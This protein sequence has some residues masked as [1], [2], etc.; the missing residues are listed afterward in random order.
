MSERTPICR[1]IGQLPV[2]CFLLTC[3]TASLLL[4]TGKKGVHPFISHERS[5]GSV[6]EDWQS[7]FSWLYLANIGP[8]HRTDGAHHEGAQA[9]SCAADPGGGRRWQSM[10]DVASRHRLNDVNESCQ[11]PADE[12]VVD[13]PLY[14][15][16]ASPKGSQREPR[17]FGSFIQS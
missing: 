1:F 14:A 11:H 3:R 13:H 10:N 4:F 8:R 6:S 15:E 9:N 7:G 16:R 12:I 2:V 5:V 17:S